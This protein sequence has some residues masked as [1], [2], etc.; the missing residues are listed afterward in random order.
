MVAEHGDLFAA[1]VDF[2]G[3]IAGDIVGAASLQIFP[4]SLF[5]IAVL[6]LREE[7]LPVQPHFISKLGLHL[8]SVDEPPF[9]CRRLAEAPE[10]LRYQLLVLKLRRLVGDVRRPGRAEL[11]FHVEPDVGVHGHAVPT[12]S[13][14]PVVGD[15]PGHL[16]TTDVVERVL[17]AGSVL[18]Q[19]THN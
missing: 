4:E 8:D 7:A 13:L 16:R 15:L 1:P 19:P 14:A 17:E 18:D 6:D 3:R 11:V 12:G 9:G 2:I 5:R 10:V